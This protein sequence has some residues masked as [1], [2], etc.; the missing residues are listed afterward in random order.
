MK[1]DRNVKELI[2]LRERTVNFLKELGEE[3][4]GTN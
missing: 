1:N 2:L 4:V 3:Y